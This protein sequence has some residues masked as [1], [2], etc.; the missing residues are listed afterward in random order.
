MKIRFLT[1]DPVTGVL[2]RDEV[3][4]VPEPG[5]VQIPFHS[6]HAEICGCQGRLPLGEDTTQ[7]G[8]TP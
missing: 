8:E 5:T 7:K 1:Y 3:R 2:V 4:E 6:I